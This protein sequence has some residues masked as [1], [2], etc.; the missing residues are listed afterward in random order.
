MNSF[1]QVTYV[2]RDQF[3]GGIDNLSTPLTCGFEALLSVICLTASAT[4]TRTSELSEVCCG[5][6]VALTSF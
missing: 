6:E 3:H 5:S 2:F 4:A 1:F